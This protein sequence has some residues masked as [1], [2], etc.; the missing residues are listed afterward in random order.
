MDSWRQQQEQDEQQQELEH[1]AEFKDIWDTLSKLDLS[2]MVEKK[3]KLSYLS[4]AS[5][6]DVLM[7]HYPSATFEN[8]EPV[9]FADKTVEVWVSVTIEGHTRKMWLPVM[10]HLNNSIASPSSRQISD[11]RMR[12][13]VKCLA[14]FGL[15]LYIY[16]GEDL[17][18]QAKDTG[19]DQ[20][21]VMAAVKCLTNCA[22]VESLED[23]FVNITGGHAK[24]SEFYKACVNAAKNRKTQLLQEAVS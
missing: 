17:P 24:Q 2:S 14:M 18:S 11:A 19:E 23:V 20:E 4:W 9:V 5:A 12:C 1:M 10:D 8:G 22:N 3:M 16:R 15:G 6:W 7:Q 13:L 21:K